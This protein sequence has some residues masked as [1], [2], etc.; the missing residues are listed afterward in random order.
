MDGVLLQ[1]I[2][3]GGSEDKLL[4]N[5]DAE[6]EKKN[7]LSALIECSKSQLGVEEPYYPSN[8]HKSAV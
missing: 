2:T 8:F 1:E 6:R 3:G 4:N 5:I 7:P